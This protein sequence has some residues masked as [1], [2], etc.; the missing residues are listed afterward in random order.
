MIYRNRVL[1][2]ALSLAV[3]LPISCRCHTAN[4]SAPKS[5]MSINR[6]GVLCYMCM[7][8]NIPAISKSILEKSANIPKDVQLDSC[9]DPFEFRS[10][11]VEPCSSVCLKVVSENEGLRIVLRGCLTTIYPQLSSDH[12]ESNSDDFSECD[13]KKQQTGEVGEIVTQTCLCT[14]SFCN[15]SPVISYDIFTTCTF[16]FIVAL[17]IRSM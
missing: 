6:T 16:M 5:V 11:I 2:L 15:S 10:A 12:L 9:D 1:F 8:K 4:A 3:L 13:I 17:T 14:P 7:S